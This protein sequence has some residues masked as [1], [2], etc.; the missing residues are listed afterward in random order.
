MSSFYQAQQVLKSLAWICTVVP[1]CRGLSDSPIGTPISAGTFANPGTNVR[2]RFRYWLPDASV[3][4]DTVAA[5]IAAAGSIGAG[6]IELLPFFEYGGELGS[7]PAGA[8][9]ATY[10]FGT[11][12]F[13]NIF[14]AVLTAHE[15]NGLVMD[16]SLGP[17]Q[18]QGVPASPDNP[19]LQ[20]DLVRSAAPIREFHAETF[21]FLSQP[22]CQR[23]GHLQKPYQ[24]GEPVSLYPSYR[25]L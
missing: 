10:N 25:L 23:T 20:W 5:D 8:D 6:G 16:F 11:V 3:D 9:W 4:V 2:P 1:L 14:A 12:P 22:P 17:N 7:M 19:G 24:A 21:R 18:G 15:E 13:R